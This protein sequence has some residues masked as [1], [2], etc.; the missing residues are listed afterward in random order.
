M[1]L[2]SQ[3]GGFQTRKMNG[4]TKGTHSQCCAFFLLNTYRFIHTTTPFQA[5]SSKR[6]V[7]GIRNS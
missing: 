6:R 3:M 7:S 2:G 4:C 1:K 5:G